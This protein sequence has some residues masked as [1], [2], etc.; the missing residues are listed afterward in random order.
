MQT[1]LA[2][3][4]TNLSESHEKVGGRLG[5]G[6]GPVC[7]L[8]LVSEW[9]QLTGLCSTVQRDGRELCRYVACIPAM[10]LCFV[11]LAT[12]SCCQAVCNQLGRSGPL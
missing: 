7:T 8:R 9:L 1:R 5:P 3:E 11:P 12:A 6:P 10:R 2:S 4:A